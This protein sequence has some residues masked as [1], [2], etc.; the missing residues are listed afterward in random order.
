MSYKVFVDENSHHADESERWL[1]GESE[2]YE[3]ALAAC[4]RIIDEFLASNHR[5]GMKAGELLELY[6]LFGED[7][8]IVPD[9]GPRWFSG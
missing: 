1:Q 2:S 7:P 4:R 8:F 5:V 3:A 9:D 6:S